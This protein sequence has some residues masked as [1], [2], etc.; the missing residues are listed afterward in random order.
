MTLVHASETVCCPYWSASVSG[1][2]LDNEGLRLPVAG[3]VD[4]YCR[5]EDFSSCPYYTEN[6]IGI[7]EQERSDVRS[8][9][10]RY[11]RL[12]RVAYANFDRDNT[13]TFDD[14]VSMV[15]FSY[16]GI[17]FELSRSVCK[18]T[19]VLF[20]LHAGSGSS[21]RSVT[22]QVKWCRPV[23]YSPSVYHFG[24]AFAGNSPAVADIRERFDL[25]AA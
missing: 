11:R 13:C 8:D 7:R 5:G 12:S 6:C 4:L 20:S 1:C 18:N 14:P 17:C 3:H 24:I 15:D 25:L 21:F 10:R 23:N 19:K 9:R 16:G 2:C 22:G